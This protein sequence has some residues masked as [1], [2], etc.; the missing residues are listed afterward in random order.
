MIKKTRAAGQ[1]VKNKKRR[2]QIEEAIKKQ[3]KI[4]MNEYEEAL[5]MT[6][7]VMEAY[8]QDM[9]IPFLGFG[10]KLPPYYTVASSCF[11]VNGDIFNPECPGTTGL[12]ET[13]RNKI[14]CLHPHGPSAYSGVI[15]LAT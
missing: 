15:D 7:S 8:D 4:Y 14:T 5:Y 6:M 3:K 10:A 13:Y 12:L 1:Q 9:M 11:A 2:K